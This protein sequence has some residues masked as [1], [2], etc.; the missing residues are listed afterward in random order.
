MLVKTITK[1]EVI[2][3]VEYMT[4]LDAKGFRWVK[5]S[6]DLQISSGLRRAIIRKDACTFLVH[7]KTGLL[8]FA[9]YLEGKKTCYIDDFVELD[10]TNK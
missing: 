6:D 10:N 2:R 5:Y 8:V 3:I 1:E 9:I 4:N 7:N